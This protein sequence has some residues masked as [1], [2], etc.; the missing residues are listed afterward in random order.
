MPCKEISTTALWRQVFATGTNNS[1]RWAPF[2]IAL[3]KII[4]VFAEDTCVDI[5]WLFG[6]TY[7]NGPE[8]SRCAA[9]LSYS[10]HTFLYTF[11]QHT[12]LPSGHVS[13]S[14]IAYRMLNN[15]CKVMSGV[16]RAKA[17]QSKTQHEHTPLNK[18]HYQF[19]VS[20]FQVEN[21]TKVWQ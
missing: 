16:L 18:T 11:R 20:I 15:P 21:T 9:A 2:T 14:E 6:S 12:L 13:F 19:V 7:E 10:A 1:H 4:H 5:I 3:T 17:I 8:Q